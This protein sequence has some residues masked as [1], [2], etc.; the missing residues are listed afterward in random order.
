MMQA[1]QPGPQGEY[2]PVTE[3]GQHGQDSK[4]VE[5]HFD[6]PGMAAEREHQQRGLADQGH[7]DAEGNRR[8]RAARVKQS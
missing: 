7:G 8:D 6:L 4:I 1:H 3:S 5:V 2:A